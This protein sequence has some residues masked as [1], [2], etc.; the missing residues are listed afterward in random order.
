M[1][2]GDFDFDSL[3]RLSPNGENEGVNDIPFPAISVIL[4]MIFIIL[5][6][7]LL[8]NMLVGLAVDDIKGIQ[9]AA[10]LEKL[11]LQVNLILSIE[12][13]LPNPIRIRFADTRSQMPLVN[14]D[15]EPWYNIRRKI[16]YILWGGECYDTYDIINKIRH[17][18][19]SHKR[20]PLTKAS[21]GAELIQ[22]RKVH[23]IEI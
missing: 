19:G 17:S 21:A 13:V 22:K 8:T 3:F 16:Q 14:T 11:T 5:M 23:T 7:I 20:M 2:T 10:S 1:T 18:E 9:E 4:W 6:P 15:K 12:E